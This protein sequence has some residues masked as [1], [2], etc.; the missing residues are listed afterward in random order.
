MESKIRSRRLALAACLILFLSPVLWPQRDI[1]KVQAAPLAAAAYNRSETQNRQCRV[2]TNGRYLVNQVT[3]KPFFITGDAPQTLAVQ[4]SDADVRTYL[5]DRASRGFNAIWVILADNYDQTGAPDNYYGHAPFDG[6]DFTNE[7]P[8][9][10]AHM[11]WVIQEAERYGIVVFA[12]PMFVGN[13]KEHYYYASVQATSEATIMAYGAWLGA[14]YANY[15]NIV[16]LLGGDTDFSETGVPQ[17]LGALAAG[18]RSTDQNHLLTF[19]ACNTACTPQSQSTMDA[20]NQP[21]KMSV[22][23]VYSTYSGIQASCARNYARTGALPTL[24]GEDRYEGEHAMTEPQVREEGYWEVLSGCTVGR[25]FGNNPIWCFNSTVPSLH[26]DSGITWQDSLNSAGSR[27]QEYFGRLMRSRE[28]WKMVPDMNHAVLTG[29][30]GSGTTLAVGACTSDGETCIVY[31]PIG[32]RQDPQIAMSHF[33]GKVRGWWFN[34]STAAATDLGTF[35]N[36]G[37]RTFTPPN[38]NDW[39]LVLD[40]ASAKFPAPGIGSFQ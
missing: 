12:N 22:N 17:K 35:R 29:G 30:Y 36:S 6:A 37:T 33:S 38:G 18:L 11:D 13:A 1:G 4:V 16:W 9:Y 32:N 3:G 20:W 14:R 21:T 15:P 7:D 24:A 39:V 8:A 26:C 27:A 31:D 10:W 23:W 2:S 40:L 34:P 5:V 25:M 28:F 19:E